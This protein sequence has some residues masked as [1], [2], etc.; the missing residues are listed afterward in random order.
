MRFVIAALLLSTT[1]L[2]LNASVCEDEVVRTFVN[3]GRIFDNP[4]AARAEYAY[5]FALCGGDTNR[6]AQILAGLALTNDASIAR[7]AV[8]W[9]SAYGRES[10]LPFLYACATNQTLREN[11]LRSILAIE[12]CTDQSVAQ[13]ALFLGDTNYTQRVR[14]EFAR[15]IFRAACKEG[16]PETNRVLGARC[17]LDYAATANEYFTPLDATMRWCDPG[18][19]F[20]KRRLSVL[21][22][23]RDLGMHPY[24]LQYV[25]NAISELVAYPEANL[26]D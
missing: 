14:S 23:V 20:S 17:V 10:Q 22:A 7:N 25:T 15:E 6:Y 26:P 21:R 1:P 9:L 4:S 3:A 11:A 19:R 18:Y 16:T 8:A 2:N 12:N 13:F 5:A 24:Q